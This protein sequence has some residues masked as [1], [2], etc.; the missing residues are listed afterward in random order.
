M[1]ENVLILGSP[2]NGAFSAALGKTQKI[3]KKAR[4]RSKNVL[5][6]TSKCDII[7]QVEL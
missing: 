6:S 2:F 1:A 4:K 7:Y 5:T 3:K